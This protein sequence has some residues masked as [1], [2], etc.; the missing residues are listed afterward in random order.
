MRERERERERKREVKNKISRRRD[1]LRKKKLGG[2]L[3]GK[4]KL[5]FQKMEGFCRRTTRAQGTSSIS[6]ACAFEGSWGCKTDTEKRKGKK[7]ARE[8][9][10]RKYRDLE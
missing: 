8:E 10:Q 1:L 9:T 2:I 4:E 6:L 3:R 5:C 7:R